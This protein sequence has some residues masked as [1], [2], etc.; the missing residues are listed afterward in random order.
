ME[1]FF[2]CVVRCLLRNTFI[3]PANNEF[4][5]SLTPVQNLA[6]ESGSHRLLIMAEVAE[7]PDNF[8]C[9]RVVYT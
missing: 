9:T 6:L 3:T 1:K 5:G 2:G 8:I 4:S 7:K